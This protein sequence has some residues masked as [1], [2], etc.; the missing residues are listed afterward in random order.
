MAKDIDSDYLHYFFRSGI[1][2][3]NGYKFSIDSPQDNQFI[4]NSVDVGNYTALALKRNPVRSEE[5]TILNELEIG[6]DYV[7]LNLKNDVL[8]GKYNNKLVQIY[9]VFPKKVTTVWTVDY[10]ML[11][12]Q[13]YTDEPKGDEHWIIMSIKPFPYL[14]RLYPK[15]IYQAGCNWTFCGSGTCGLTLS[16]Y[17]TNVNLSAQSDGVTLTCS[18][19]QAADYFVPGYVQIK[20]GSLQGAVRPILTNSTSSVTVRVPFDSTIA[21]GVNVDIV[22]LCAKNYETCDTDFSNY[23]NYGGY[24]WVPKEPIL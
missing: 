11:L 3:L 18:H 7:D 5:G 17:V 1:T 24:P 15:R 23:A 14:D 21:N 6:L 8:S 13:G 4:A 10:E 19:G 12:F 2:V 16:N 22:K 9:L 20:S